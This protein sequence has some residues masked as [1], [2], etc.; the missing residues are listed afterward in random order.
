MGP[1]ED[2]GVG[3]LPQLVTLGRGSKDGFV[4]RLNSLILNLDCETS[5]ISMAE[6]FVSRVTQSVTPLQC[7]SLAWECKAS[8][9]GYQLSARHLILSPQH[10]SYGSV[11]AVIEES[12][13]IKDALIQRIREIRVLRLHLV[14]RGRREWRYPRIPR[15]AEHT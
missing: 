13:W 6:A 8:T 2:V 9:T 4:C 14:Q 1:S 12:C 15:Y 10:I 11:Y 5:H 7:T 3:V